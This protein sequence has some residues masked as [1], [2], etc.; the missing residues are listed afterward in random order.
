M[1]S[2]AFS[3]ELANEC[4]SEQGL[5]FFNL[6][7]SVVGDG[8][9]EMEK[10]DF[11]FGTEDG[12]EFGKQH[13]LNS[14]VMPVIESFFGDK[15]CVLAHWLRYSAYPGHPS[16]FRLGGPEAG[17]L[18]LVVLLIAKGSRMTYWID[19]HRYALPVT[20]GK[21]YL[22]EGSEPALVAAGCQKKEET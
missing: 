22:H 13:I 1:A 18:A 14:R 9:R 16:S 19:S 12:L 11:V 8:V 6:K 17:R 4:L 21:R 20:E 15:I 3:E 10:R 7:D 2:T 5:G